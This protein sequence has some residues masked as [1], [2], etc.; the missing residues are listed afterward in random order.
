MARKQPNFALCET[1]G[2]TSVT[3]EPRPVQTILLHHVG[4]RQIKKL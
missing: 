4:E 2:I 1:S 3:L